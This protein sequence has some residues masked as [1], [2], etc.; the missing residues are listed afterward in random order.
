MP[1]F[2][3]RRQPA[4]Q[5][6]PLLAEPVEPGGE[7]GQAAAR[8]V[9]DRGGGVDAGDVAL[10]RRHVD[11]EMRQQVHLGE[12][13]EI[14]GLENVGVF[15][16]L[17]LAF[18]DREQGD[19]ARFAEVEGGGADEVADILDEQ[20]PARRQR[21]LIQ[22]VADHVCVEVA[23]LA[24]VDLHRRRTGRANALGVVLGLLVAFDDRRRH[25][26]AERL[27]GLHQQGRLAGAGAGEK[28]DGEDAVVA[29]AGAV[30]RGI[31]VVLGEDAVLQLHHALLAG[32]GGI[33]VRVVVS[34]GMVMAP[35][36]VMAVPIGARGAMGV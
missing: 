20:Q 18:G 27:Q 25:A 9:Q 36:V 17:V 28:V 1:A 23:A 16:R 8:T 10:D 6:A 34:V 12:Q 29:K 31:G 14:G 7:A 3:F 19:P 4:E 2:R 24:G 33:V 15:E 5:M 30:A 13:H 26:P 22:G 21:Q 32:A 35:M 11:V